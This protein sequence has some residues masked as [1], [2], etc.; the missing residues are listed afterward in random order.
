MNTNK[1]YRVCTNDKEFDAWCKVMKKKL[2]KS[3]ILDHFNQGYVE[4]AKAKY[5]A[6]ASFVCYWEI[7]SNGT[8]A[9]LAPA[10]T[11]ASLIHLLHRFGEQESFEEVQV[12]SMMLSNFL[13]LL[14]KVNGEEADEEE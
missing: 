5:L 3:V 8:F 7:Y 4:V 12:T 13:R 10:I 6:R 14:T 1:L 2:S 11:Q 9:K